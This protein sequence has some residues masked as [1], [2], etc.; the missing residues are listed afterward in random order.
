M[1]FLPS[2]YVDHYTA[3]NDSLQLLDT[4]PPLTKDMIKCIKNKKD[5]DFVI[6]FFVPYDFSYK[7]N[8]VKECK[9]IK[10]DPRHTTSN[11]KMYNIKVY[12]DFNVSIK[13]PT[14]NV[15]NF[16]K[17]Q[18][19]KMAEEITQKKREEKLEKLE[20][21]RKQLEAQINQIKRSNSTELRKIRNR[22]NYYVGDTLESYA[23]DWVA[24]KTNINTKKLDYNDYGL[25]KERADIFFSFLLENDILDTAF[26]KVFNINSTQE[27]SKDQKFK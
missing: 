17:R 4:A 7:T 11:L 14:A 22:N 13:I 16:M 12:N 24:N 23:R 1:P 21:R 27:N 20:T 8:I 3:N 25:T 10:I 9:A 15:L 26:E 19:I 6:F 2:M 18:K 5:L